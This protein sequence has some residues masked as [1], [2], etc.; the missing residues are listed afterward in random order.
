VLARRAAGRFFRIDL[1]TR[2]P[3][4]PLPVD[5]TPTNVGGALLVGKPVVEP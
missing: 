4:A 2:A 5:L 3:G 1:E